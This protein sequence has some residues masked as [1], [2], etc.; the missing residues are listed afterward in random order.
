[1][2]HFLKDD[3]KSSRFALEILAENPNLNNLQTIGV[4]LESAVFNGFKNIIHNLNRLGFDRN[5]IKRD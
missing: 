3:T 2:L 4:D 5:L 1:M